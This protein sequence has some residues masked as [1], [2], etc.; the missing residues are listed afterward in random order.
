MLIMNIASKAKSSTKKKIPAKTNND[1]KNS[2][3]TF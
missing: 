3:L 1:E 2:I